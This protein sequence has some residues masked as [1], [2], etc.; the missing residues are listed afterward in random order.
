M[1]NI[2]KYSKKIYFRDWQYQSLGNSKSYNFIFDEISIA[3][4]IKQW[5]LLSK[6]LE[7][8]F[9][10]NKINI[11][12]YPKVIDDRIKLNLNIEIENEKF[13]HYHS[14]LSYYDSEFIKQFISSNKKIIEIGPGFGRM[15]PFFIDYKNFSYYEP[16]KKILEL[17]SFFTKN[18]LKNNFK[19]LKTEFDLTNTE[20]VDLYFSMDCLGE[21]STKQFVNYMNIFKKNLN[22][23]GIILIRDWWWNKDNLKFLL[24]QNDYFH[25]SKTKIN[26]I[27]VGE[28]NNWYI[29]RIK[30]V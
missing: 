2:K 24:K 30:N 27:D 14:T 8:S 20:R 5:V 16:I 25:I 21:I 10:K 9:K 17:S 12:S 29:L 15:F 23:N 22:K 19:I 18:I 28:N 26:Y 6:Y 7:E 3:E 11:V 13:L 1:I 4:K